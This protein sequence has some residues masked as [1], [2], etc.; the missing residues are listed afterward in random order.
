M[1]FNVL[2]KVVKLKKDHGTKVRKVIEGTGSHGRHQEIL[3]GT[4]GQHPKMQRKSIPGKKINIYPDKDSFDWGQCHHTKNT[5]SIKLYPDKE[6][7]YHQIQ[8]QTYQGRSG[9]FI[10]M[11]PDKMGLNY[12]GNGNDHL[13]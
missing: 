13:I 10:E 8:T 4:S 2:S 11:Y 1:K 7:V 6:G 5:I 12:W 9:S 3:S